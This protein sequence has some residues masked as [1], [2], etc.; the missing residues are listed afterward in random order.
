MRHKGCPFS[1]TCSQTLSWGSSARVKF[2]CLVIRWHEFPKMCQEQRFPGLKLRQSHQ[3][4]LAYRGFPKWVPLADS[5]TTCHRRPKILKMNCRRIKLEETKLTLFVYNS[6]II[7]WNCF[8]SIIPYQLLQCKWGHRP[9][10]RAVGALT[11]LCASLKL[12]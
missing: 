11:E 7:C 12:M 8:E 9:P 2:L 1:P 10:R 5:L 3:L 6:Y 4:R